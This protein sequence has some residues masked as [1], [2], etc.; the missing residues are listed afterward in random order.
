VSSLIRKILKEES[1]DFD[2]T[3]SINPLSDFGDYFY[4]IGDYEYRRRNSPGLYIKRDSSWWRNWIEDV[5]MSHIAL[6]EDVA[7]LEDM[8]G[9]LVNPRRGK[10]KEYKVLAKDVYNFVTPTSYLSGLNTIQDTASQILSAYNS[11][12]L[13]SEQNNLTILEV[14]DVFTVWLDK[15]DKEGKP[16]HSNNKDE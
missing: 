16:L 13:Y 12:G 4:G 10:T 11:F 3:N 5:G 1:E 2:W 14:M 15:M 9:D 8:V 7:D 6:M